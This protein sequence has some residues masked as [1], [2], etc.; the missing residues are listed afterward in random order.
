MSDWIEI[1]VRE[2]GV[3]EHVL[4]DHPK[5]SLP[6]AG[7]RAVHQLYVVPG[8]GGPLSEAP[9]HWMPLPETPHEQAE[10]RRRFEIDE[11]YVVLE[12]FP[13]SGEWGVHDSRKGKV[14]LFDDEEEA[15][16][17]AVCTAAWITAQA[18]AK[19]FGTKVQAW[20]VGIGE[21]TA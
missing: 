16:E 14:R 4:F 19:G 15:R 2:P 3:D 12:R 20:S 5:W 9:T 1:S 8:L 17:H 21:A 6:Q 11:D 7:W 10:E 18:A 13:S